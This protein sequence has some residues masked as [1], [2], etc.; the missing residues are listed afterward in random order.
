MSPGKPVG[1]P[2]GIMGILWV[3]FYVKIISRTKCFV[4]T[5]GRSFFK[6]L[7]NDKAAVLSEMF[8]EGRKVTEIFGFLPVTR[9]IA[10]TSTINT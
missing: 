7:Q 2:S 3:M 6:M 10:A 5:G 1:I 4:L 9:E 8:R